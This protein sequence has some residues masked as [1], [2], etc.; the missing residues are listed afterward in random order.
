MRPDLR[1]TLLLVAAGLASAVFCIFFFSIT[2]YLTGAI[3]GAA[4]AICLQK[5]RIFDERQAGWFVAVATVAYLLSFGLAVK[6]DS[7]FPPVIYSSRP[8]MEPPIVWLGGGVFGGFLLIGGALWLLRPKPDGIPFSAWALG[9]AAWG[10]V[11]AISGWALGPSLGSMLLKLLEVLPLRMA[12][13]STRDLYSIYILWQTGMALMLGLMLG[14]RRQS[15][16]TEA[17]SQ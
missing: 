11:L 4:T 6:L 9:G 16:S 8:D 15:S 2:V 17:E 7:A 14:G 13:R 1:A 3:F 10:G 12:H 5:L